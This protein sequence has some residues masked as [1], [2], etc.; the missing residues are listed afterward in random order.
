MSCRTCRSCARSTRRSGSARWPPRDPTAFAGT[1][2][3]LLDSPPGDRDA[4]R[5]RVL[6]RY[7]PSALADRYLEAYTRLVPETQD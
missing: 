7:S 2:E 3:A 1:L 6:T 4:A 5:E